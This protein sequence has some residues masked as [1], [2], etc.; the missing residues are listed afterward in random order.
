MDVVG[1]AVVKWVIVEVLWVGVNVW[2]TVEIVADVFGVS[3]EV[4]T[5]A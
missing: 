4:T 5:A 3:S 1:R 2:W